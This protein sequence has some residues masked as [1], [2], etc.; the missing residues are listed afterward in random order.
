MRY[1][2]KI[3]TQKD[4]YKG[5]VV[6]LQV[7]EVALPDN[8]IGHREMIKHQGAVAVAALTKD[9]EVLLVEQFRV[10]CDE[11]LLEIPAGKL[12]IGEE[13][14]AAALRELQEETGYTTNRLVK[15]YEGYTT[16]GFTNE[17]LRFYCAIDVEPMAERIAMDEDEFIELIKIPLA[18]I[19]QMLKEQKFKD[20]KTITGLQ[21]LVA[22]YGEN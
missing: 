21:F 20:L 10:T 16:P 5:S 14:D 2:E 4:I 18:D 17:L 3:I 7:A 15:M 6:H 13:P 1:Q 11:F 9:K 12:E 19:P 8:K 22:N